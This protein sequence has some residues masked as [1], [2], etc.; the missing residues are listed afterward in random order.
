MVLEVL[1]FQAVV[2]VEL[3]C[4]VH[5]LLLENHIAVALE[6][7]LAVEVVAVVPLESLEL[8]LVVLESSV[9]RLEPCEAPSDVPLIRV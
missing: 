2:Q 6:H 7:F 3:E 8:S 1:Q 4:Q 9:S 5:V